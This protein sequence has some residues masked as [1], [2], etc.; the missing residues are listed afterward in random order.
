MDQPIYKRP[1]RALILTDKQEKFCQEVAKGI[2]YTESYRRAHPG[3]TN[4][5]AA[6][7]SQRYLRMQKIL[8]RIGEIQRDMGERN[9]ITEDEIVAQFRKIR[10]EAIECGNYN[11]ANAANAWLGK[12][13]GMF[14]RQDNPLNP[15]NASNLSVS[16]LARLAGVDVVPLLTDQT[17][18]EGNA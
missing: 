7:N 1:T 2:N 15:Y 5:T 4:R 18:T 3:C 16:Q 11:A 10:K 6:V 17:K 12:I 8:R 14:D 13:A 9:A